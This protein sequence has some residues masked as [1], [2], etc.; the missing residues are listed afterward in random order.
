[1]RVL[2][3]QNAELQLDVPMTRTSAGNQPLALPVEAFN[4]AV[5][6]G[7]VP[8]SEVVSTLSA[9]SRAKRVTFAGLRFRNDLADSQGQVGTLPRPVEL[10]SLRL[11]KCEGVGVLLN[12]L[13]TMS[14]IRPMA[15]KTLSS[16]TLHEVDFPAV[17]DSLRA[18]GAVLTDLTLDASG[19]PIFAADCK[20]VAAVIMMLVFVLTIHHSVGEHTTSGL[21]ECRELETF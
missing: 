1:M 3:A 20:I 12:A 9:L 10:V 17:A 13:R 11:R 16:R 6:R 8:A 5:R 15:L 18:H 19:L 21:S 4:W 7:N 2:D 14:A